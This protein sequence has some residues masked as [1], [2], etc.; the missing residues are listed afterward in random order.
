MISVDL[1][2]AL[3]ERAISMVLVLDILYKLSEKPGTDM[4]NWEHLAN[5]RVWIKA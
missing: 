1:P 4:Y 3:K 5:V 2:A